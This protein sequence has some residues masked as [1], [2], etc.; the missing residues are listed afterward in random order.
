M[1]KTILVIQNFIEKNGLT[2]MVIAF[3]VLIISVLC[4]RGNMLYGLNIFSI[5]GYISLAYIVIGGTIF[6]IAGIVNSIKDLKEF[7]KK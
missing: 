4:V 6:T 3:V 7:F 1:K 5:T 2:K